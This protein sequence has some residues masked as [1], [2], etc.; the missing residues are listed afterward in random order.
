MTILIRHYPHPGASENFKTNGEEMETSRYKIVSLKN[1]K[2]I[3]NV[4]LKESSVWTRAFK[5]RMCPP[6]PYA[7][8]KR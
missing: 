3:S 7:C 1:E 5:S 2:L 4:T 8:R 6:Y